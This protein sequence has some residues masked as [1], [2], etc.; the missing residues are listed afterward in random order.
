MFRLLS[1]PNKPE[2]AHSEI[3]TKFSRKI[4]KQEWLKNVSTKGAGGC[5][6]PYQML[7][8]CKYTIVKAC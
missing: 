3:M 8:N 7:K 2:R 4:D 1:T 6:L 5:S